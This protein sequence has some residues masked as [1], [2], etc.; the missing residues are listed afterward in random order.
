[1]SHDILV[2]SFVIDVYKRMDSAGY[3]VY[4]VGGG[5]RD[6]LMG[7][8]PNDWDIA[9]SATPEQIQEVF[10]E[11]CFYDNSFGTVGVVVKGVRGQEVQGVGNSEEINDI[12]HITTYR[13]EGKYSDF[14]RPD[15][16]EWGKTIRDDL[17]RRDF[18][19]NAIAMKISGEGVR[20]QGVGDKGQVI[21]LGVNDFVLVDPYGG[22]VDLH[23]KVIKAVGDP[24]ERFEED[25]LRMLRAARFYSQLNFE[26]ALDTVEAIHQ[27]AK[28]ISYISGER[29]RDELWKILSSDRAYEG[30]RLLDDLELLQYILPEVV[31]GRGLDQ[32]GHHI[33]DVF[34]HSMNALKFCPSTNPLVRL[35]ALLHDIGKPVT[36]EVRDGINT[37]YNHDIVGAK[38]VN[39]ISYRLHLSK[40][41]R[42]KLHT[43]VRFHMFNVDTIL[44]DA[45]IRRFIAK[46]GVENI[47]D[48]M[49][50][51]IGDRL[52]SGTKEAEGWRLKEYKKRIEQLLMPTFTVKDLVI[53]GNDV[54][55][56]LDIKPGRKI[57]ETLSLLFEEVL[58]DPERNN[59]EYLEKRVLELKGE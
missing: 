9:T 34:E 5:V 20:E 8:I 42:S 28:N 58:D 1:M 2:P 32:R 56:I 30:V 19:I 17:E 48:M 33:Y 43:L 40:K 13:S 4:L 53:D 36:H 21:R 15:N 51:R 54:M 41:D 46:V 50:L 52:G 38:L 10:G 31:A 24:N 23:Q 27:K 35:A 59:K 39:S 55:R 14:R 7:R 22:L 45:A 49:D 11:D 44:T 18:T 6:A 26:I 57:G 37:F 47:S 12:V 29:I 16:V 25:A 3:E